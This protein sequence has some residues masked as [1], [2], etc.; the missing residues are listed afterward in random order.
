MISLKQLKKNKKGNVGVLIVFVFVLALVLIVGFLMSVGSS[1]LNWTFDEA[2][3]L[4]SDLGVVEGTNFTEVA[5][6]TVTPLNTFVQNIQ[7]VVGVLYVLMLVG[8]I[9]V[10][11]AFRT[12]PN[13]W[14]IGLFFGLVLILILM[15][16]FI[17]NIYE[18][19]YSGTDDLATRMQE[20]TILSWMILY[21]PLIFAIIAFIAGAIMFSGG[22]EEGV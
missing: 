12:T 2:V 18:D 10:A 9:G 20:Q 4:V 7:W 21:S 14:L 11:F 16:M 15:S 6:F 5:G 19:F 22:T 13:K 3:P 8:S 17:S 1:I